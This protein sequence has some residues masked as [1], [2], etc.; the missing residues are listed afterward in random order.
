MANETPEVAEV[1]A[2]AGDAPGGMSDIA[3]DVLA[4][5]ESEDK[6]QETQEASAE[7]ST[8]ED[9]SHEEENKQVDEAKKA[10]AKARKW[11]L[12]A[13]G[14]EY[15]VDSE[16][17]LIAAAQRGLAAE[18]NWQKVRQ[19]VDQMRQT[20]QAKLRE[21]EER[22]K[23]A[24]ERP[25]EWLRSRTDKAED[26]AEELLLERAREALAMEE[27]TPR[28]RQLYLE[29]K[30]VAAKL[31][32]AEK[33]RQGIKEAEETRMVTEQQNQI[34]AVFSKALTDNKLP[35]NNTT[36]RIMSAIYR[37]NVQRGVELSSEQCAKLTKAHLEHIAKDINSG[38]IESLSAEDFVKQYPKQADA[39]RQ[40]YV[41][42]AKGKN[43]PAEVT[44]VP[45]KKV[46]V[47]SNDV[48]DKGKQWDNY[49]EKLKK[50]GDALRIKKGFW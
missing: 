47:K 12:K 30:E 18:Q 16:E 22:E 37:A 44:D 41:S 3:K 26:I 7:E 46:A 11:K 27:M 38:S 19:E 21:V 33:E 8:E 43:A 35:A 40:Y 25:A 42:K 50:E 28:E 34:A 1:V 39:I 17:K 32:K 13:N 24:A 5:Q 49:V 20:L 23:F 10:I 6:A 4:E 48:P 9:N 2:D 15:E 36:V 31:E 14:K 29:K 45:R